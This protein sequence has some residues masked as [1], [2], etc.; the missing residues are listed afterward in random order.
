MWA[1]SFSITFPLQRHVSSSLL[2]SFPFQTSCK[3]YP[4]S[5]S[6]SSSSDE[7]IRF[8]GENNPGDDPSDATSR[9]ADSRFAGPSSGRRRSLRRM[10]TA[11][12]RL[13]DEEGKSRRGR[14]LP[15][16]RRRE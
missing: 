4:Q 1:D 11:F 14:L 9:R 6:S 16:G 5:S 3:T 2:L 15:L 8:V 12:R 13:I 7:S 10:A